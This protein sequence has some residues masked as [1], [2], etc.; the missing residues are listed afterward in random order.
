[1]SLAYAFSASMSWTASPGIRRG[2]VKTISDAMSSDG[3]AMSSR[4]TTY[5][6][7]T[8]R[9][10]AP[11]RA[12][13]LR[14][15]PSPGAQRTGSTPRAR[16]S[17]GASQLDRSRRPPDRDGLL[18]DAALEEGQQE[19]D[20]EGGGGQV[21]HPVHPAAV[22]VEQLDGHVGDEAGPDAVGD[23]PRERHDEHGDEG[24]D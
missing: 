7:S 12:H 6:L 15:R 24:R 23:R 3:I 17:G 1:M 16:A 11:I 9:S 22:A 2:S 14:C 21:E 13:L 10:R 8:D 18:A 20:D 5:R 4:L 19:V